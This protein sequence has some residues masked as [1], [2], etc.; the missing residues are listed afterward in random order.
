MTDAIQ[1]GYLL[2]ADLSGFT[3][4]MARTELDHGQA[5]LR[6]ILASIVESLTPTMTLSEVEGDA[7][8]VYATG[9]RLSRG[10]LVAELIESTYASFR[11]QQRTMIHNATCPCRACRHIAD[12][13]LKFVVHFGDFVVQELV[14]QRGPVGTSVNLLHRLVKNH[15]TE[16]TG[17]EAYVLFTA[18]ALGQ[19]GLEPGGMRAGTERYEHIGHVN[20][21]AAD[22]RGRYEQICTQRRIFLEPDESHIVLRRTFDAPRPVI[23]DWLA[24]TRKRT[25]WMQRSDWIADLR[26]GGRTGPRASNHCA[27]YKAIEYVLDWQPFDYYTVRFT[28][29]GL[30]VLTTV[31]LARVESATRLSWRMKVEMPLPRLLLEMIARRL[32]SR[33][34]RLEPSFDELER[35]ITA[36]TQAAASPPGDPH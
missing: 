24:D 2:I 6:Q 36:E 8:F 21:F 17:W 14:G 1:S 33:R 27:T 35:L 29:G 4:Y 34:L 19:T 11:D 7:V 18:D 15:V 13:D 10:E 3:S 22:L 23:W 5:I 20:T 28:S 16:D 31:A 26:P 30:D 9:Q 25:R 12:L 32:V